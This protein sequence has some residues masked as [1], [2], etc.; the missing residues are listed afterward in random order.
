[1]RKPNDAR[2]T[3]RRRARFVGHPTAASQRLRSRARRRPHSPL[4]E[5]SSHDVDVDA[6]VER[7]RDRTNGVRQARCLAILPSPMRSQTRQSFPRECSR[8]PLQDVIVHRQLA[9]LALRLR[10]PVVLH[11]A[12]GTSAPY[13]HPPGTPH[14]RRRSGAP[15]APVSCASAS[16][17]SARVGA[18]PPPPYGARSRP[19]RSSPPAK[20]PAGLAT[21]IRC[22]SAGRRLSHTHGRVGTPRTRTVREGAVRRVSRDGPACMGGHMHEQL[23]VVAAATATLTDGAS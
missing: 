7:C 13:G 2:L 23:T 17:P 19:L 20:T 3:S 11:R 16:R 21:L 18:G 15:A 8:R 9:E 10:E 5:R 14:A 22:R 4:V 12:A 1:M 6:A